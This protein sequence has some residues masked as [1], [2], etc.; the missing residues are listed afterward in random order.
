MRVKCQYC[1]KMQLAPRLASHEKRCPWR[2]RAA[3]IAARV[4]ATKEV[5]P[6]VVPKPIQVIEPIPEAKYKLGGKK[7]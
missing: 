7:K 1:N 6:V 2:R 3:R 4:E 5:V